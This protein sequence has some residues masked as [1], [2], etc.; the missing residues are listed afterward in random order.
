[1]KS[2]IVKRFTKVNDN[3]VD[4]PDGISQHNKSRKRGRESS[5]Y[6]RQR[7]TC[8]SARFSSPGISITGVTRSAL[9]LVRLSSP[10]IPGNGERGRNDHRPEVGPLPL[11]ARP[12][13][14]PA[15]AEISNS[16]FHPSDASW[17]PDSRLSG[18][19]LAGSPPNR[20][21][22]D[23]PNT[24]SFVAPHCSAHAG[25][26]LSAPMERRKFLA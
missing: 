6:L 7:C 9:T 11:A 5:A 15:S 24:S 13:S 3:R 20:P 25:T 8:A 23:R 17:C 10:V 21:E 14:Y 16:R 26:R 1:M 2:S 18:Y 12:P 4:V 22:E 19:L